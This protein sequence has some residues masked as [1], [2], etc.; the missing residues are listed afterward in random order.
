LGDIA[1]A[2]RVRDR[3]ISDEFHNFQASMVSDVFRA[4]ASRSQVILK[5][6]PENNAANKLSSAAKPAIQVFGSSTVYPDLA[7]HSRQ[8][9]YTPWTGQLDYSQAGPFTRGSG[10]RLPLVFIQVR[11]E[12]G[13]AWGHPKSWTGSGENCYRTPKGT[14]LERVPSGVVT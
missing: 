8:Q 10:L 1:A 11:L 2:T 9:V 13:G 14:L 7:R 3:R 4:T 6:N 5:T 12:S